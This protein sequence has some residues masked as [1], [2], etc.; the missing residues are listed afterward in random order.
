MPYP[1]RQALLL[2]SLMTLGLGQAYA[3]GRTQVGVYV[4]PSWGPWGP[5]GY[6]S[7]WFYPPPVVVV[8]APTPPAPPVYI[9]RTP[10]PA[11]A[12]AP[13]AHWYY[14]ASAGAYYP[15]VKSCPEPWQPVQPHPEK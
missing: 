6:P 14:C 12:P 5:W 9:E 1:I 8:P 3:H 15:Y 4:G 10:E 11:P 7:P 2:L 13:A